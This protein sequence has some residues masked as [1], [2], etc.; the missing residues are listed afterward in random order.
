VLTVK[1][2]QQFENQIAK[3]QD[4]PGSIVKIEEFPNDYD[5]VKSM[6]N[7]QTNEILINN[8][9][10]FETHDIELVGIIFHESRHAFQWYQINN[11]QNAV[12]SAEILDVWKKE[13]LE[14]EQHSANMN[15]SG[16]YLKSIEIDAVAYAD[17]N[18]RSMIKVGLEIIPEMKS[19]VE[20]RQQEILSK[21]KIF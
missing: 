2:L 15:D 10:I 9:L 1:Q 20:I 21:E 11:L 5:K 14:Y 19:Y 4:R 12:E 8:N 13:F 3:I 18:L 16:Y 7:Y 17:L 6:Y